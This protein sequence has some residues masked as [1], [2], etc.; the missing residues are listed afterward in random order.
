VQDIGLVFPMMTA[1]ARAAVGQDRGEGF[2]ERRGPVSSVVGS[3]VHRP[4]DLIGNTVK[5]MRIATGEEAG[6]AATRRLAA[7]KCWGV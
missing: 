6:T 7:K 3:S 4:A 2:G 1:A 5:V